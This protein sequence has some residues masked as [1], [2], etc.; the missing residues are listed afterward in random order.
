MGLSGLVWENTF[1][2]YFSEW[3]KPVATI[4]NCLCICAVNCFVIIS[5]YFSISVN[6]K[7][8]VSLLLTVLIYTFFFSSVYN[9][10]IG[11]IRGAISRMLIFS[12]HTYWFVNA[13]IYLIF[14]APL[15]NLM[16]DK[17]TKMYQM[18]F[19]GFLLFISCYL[20]FIWHNSLNP[21]GY[22]L[23]QFILMYSIGRF[24]SYYP[25]K[26][27]MNKAFMIYFGSSVIT[28]G[29]MFI[30]WYTG[31][32]GRSWQMTYYNN[33]LIVLAAIGLFIFFS[34]IHINSVTINKLASSA[35]AIYM[36]QSSLLCNVY[37]Y[38]FINWLHI[39]VGGVYGLL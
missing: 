29:L 23:I 34:K 10:S 20:G 16:F 30:L 35:F 5:G 38:R 15:I 3:E 39:T 24:I 9:L 31:H 26:I 22:N 1:P 7:K 33:P 37:Y 4:V 27:S 36:V 28:G 21:N 18:Y 2:M 25:L 14:F 17:M 6:K 8:F 13:Y 12:H 11:N 32:P 19:I